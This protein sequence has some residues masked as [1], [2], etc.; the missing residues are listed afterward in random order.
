[1]TTR[2]R[3]SQLVLDRLAANGSVR[4][5]DFEQR[6]EKYESGWGQR[7]PIADTLALLWFEG[8]IVPARRAGGRRWGLAADGVGGPLPSIPARPVEL[9][10]AAVRSLRALGIATQQ[11]VTK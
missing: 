2:G 6:A 7:S 11:Q 5:S 9:Q 1:M 4:A 8:Q 3:F 10:P